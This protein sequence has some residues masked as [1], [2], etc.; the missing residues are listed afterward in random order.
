MNRQR[1]IGLVL[2][3]AGFAIAMT[4]GLVLAVQ[5]S[6]DSGSMPGDALPGAVAAFIPVALLTTAG[7]Y[8]YRRGADVEEDDA[9]SEMRLQ[10]DLL[11]R[12]H[13]QGQMTVP[14][15]ARDL[16]IEP[17]QVRDLVRQLVALNIF[18][19]LAN[20]DD[21][22]LIAADAARLRSIDQCVRCGTTLTIARTGI[23]VCP[24]C[25]TQYYLPEL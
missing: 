25:G 2:I 10:R 15:L 4:V 21:G 18:S 24:V 12:L 5:V 13:G 11:D 14:D 20:W 7:L 8:V 19:G 9:Q 3:A 23:T 22:T 6:R 17:L 1:L 16:G